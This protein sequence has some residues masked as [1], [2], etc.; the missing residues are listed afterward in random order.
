MSKLIKKHPLH[1]LLLFY[2]SIEEGKIKL[3][4]VSLY[5][6]LQNLLHR[7]VVLFSLFLNV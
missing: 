2:V 6:N 1:W 5:N 3:N 4:W 7:N